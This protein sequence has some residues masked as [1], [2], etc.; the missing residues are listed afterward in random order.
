MSIYKYIFLALLALPLLASCSNED[1][2]TPSNA[3]INGFAPEASDNSQTAQIRNAFFKATGAYLLFND[4]LVSKST[5]GQPELFDITYALVGSGSVSSQ[6]YHYAYITEATEQQKAA[7]ALQKYLTRRLGKQVPFSFLLVDDIY[8][9]NSNG[10]TKRV[11]YLLGTRGYVISTGNGEMFDDPKSYFNDMLLS[12]VIDR[13]N[14]QSA[15][16]TDAFYAFSKDHYGQ[17]LTDDDKAVDNVEHVYG[18]ME[19][20]DG[21]NEGDYY[22]PYQSRDVKD[23]VSAV[24]TMTREEFAAQYGDYALMV[25]KYDMMRSIITDMGF[26]LDAEE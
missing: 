4:T 11:A 15:S 17:N 3:D 9:T 22:L 24:L 18:F 16:V 5:N 23:Y 12:I 26:N 7:D 20:F 1:D 21:W 25:E 19:K 13:F 6:N 14:R 2:L 8:Y 10:R